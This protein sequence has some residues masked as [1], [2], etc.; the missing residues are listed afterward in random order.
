LIIILI[1]LSIVVVFHGKPLTVMDVTLICYS[2]L[3]LYG[4]PLWFHSLNKDIDLKIDRLSR[5]A[6]GGAL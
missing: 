6:K 1:F 5:I 4:A 2:W 3:T